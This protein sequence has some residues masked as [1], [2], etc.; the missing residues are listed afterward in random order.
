MSICI[1]L[2]WSDARMMAESVG[3]FS[4]TA[5]LDR[6]RRR[7]KNALGVLAALLV[8]ILLYEGICAPLLR[9]RQRQRAIIAVKTAQ[10]QQLSTSL[11]EFRSIEKRLLLLQNMIDTRRRDFTLF[12]FLNQISETLDLGKHIVLMKPTHPETIGPYR[13]ARI[14]MKWKDVGLDTLVQ[15]LGQV[16]ESGNLV[17]VQKLALQP[18]TENPALLDVGIQVQTLER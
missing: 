13:L 2:Q 5:M 11:D 10:L 12:S 16:E 4:F 6:M 18:S 15:W 8:A 9:W 1:G 3:D 14:E 17:H 7:E